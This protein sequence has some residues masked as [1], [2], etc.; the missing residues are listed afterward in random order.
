MRRCRQSVRHMAKCRNPHMLFIVFLYYCLTRLARLAAREF[1]YFDQPRLLA[2]LLIFG[3]FVEPLPS[4]SKNA[5]HLPP[6]T[7][8]FTKN[9]TMQLWPFYMVTSACA[10]CSVTTAMLMHRV[11]RA[12]SLRTGSI[13]MA[14]PAEESIIE[15]MVESVERTR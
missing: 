4:F 15:S 6:V 8:R 2:H 12:S 3:Y 10:H 1:L 9:K 13:V 14:I 7:H 5:Y 11:H